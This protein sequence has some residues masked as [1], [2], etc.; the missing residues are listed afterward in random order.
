[1]LILNSEESISDT[2]R[3]C[4]FYGS[5]L[6]FSNLVPLSFPKVC[7]V[8][9]SL[10]RSFPLS[11]ELADGQRLTA[12]HERHHERAHREVDGGAG[13]GSCS[14]ADCC[15]E[16]SQ[17]DGSSSLLGRR[18]PVLRAADPAALRKVLQGSRFLAIEA[19]GSNSTHC[20]EVDC[21]VKRKQPE[22]FW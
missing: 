16:T 21:A 17:L 4:H 2:L 11:S 14:K 5:K 9:L 19:T 6:T 3:N 8:R 20:L 18:Q 7:Q 10:L 1:L 22:G 13:G 15:G 12:I